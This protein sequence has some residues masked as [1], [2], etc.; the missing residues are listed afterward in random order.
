[1]M[2]SGMRF[3]DWLLPEQTASWG[4]SDGAAGRNLLE[5][6]ETQETLV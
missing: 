5:V 6:Q 2:V 1:M 3:T 4:F